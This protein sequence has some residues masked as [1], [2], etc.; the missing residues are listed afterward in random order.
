[1]TDFDKWFGASTVRDE[2]GNPK[3]VFHGTS[4]GGWSAFRKTKIGSAT[5]ADLLYGPGFYFT[6]DKSVAEEYAEIGL[7]DNPA[8]L[9]NSATINQILRAR[10]VEKKIKQGSVS[11]WAE[12]HIQHRHPSS[13]LDQIRL[14]DGIS[15]F[16]KEG[17]SIADAFPGR[18]IKEVFLSIKK[19]FNPEKDRIK[20]SQLPA[21]ILATN[22]DIKR[23]RA[24]PSLG[25]DLSYN[26]LNSAGIEKNEINKIL[27]D[28][29]Y[30]GITHTGGQ[31]MGDKEHR[32]WI[33]FEPD[34]IKYAAS[35]QELSAGQAVAPKKTLAFKHRV[36]QRFYPD[37][38]QL[39]KKLK[40]ELH[41]SPN[42]GIVTQL[43]ELGGQQRGGSSGEEPSTPVQRPQAMPSPVVSTPSVA[44]NPTSEAST[45]AKSA[46]HGTPAVSDSASNPISGNLSNLGDD[47]WSPRNFT[48]DDLKS[49][50][51]SP[52][53]NP[54]GLRNTSISGQN[55]SV[56]SLGNPPTGSTSDAHELGSVN[57]P[58]ASGSNVASVNRPGSGVSFDKVSPS[59]NVSQSQSVASIGQSA[60]AQNSNGISPKNSSSLGKSG[61]SIAN[62]PQ[63]S[64]MLD[65]LKGVASAT[66]ALTK[67]EM[68]HPG[69]EDS[70]L[71]HQS[72]R[73]AN[74]PSYGNMRGVQVGGGSEASAFHHGPES[75][76]DNLNAM[77][78]VLGNSG[79][80][81]DGF[82]GG[83]DNSNS[84]VL[85]AIKQLTEIV[86]AI[87]DKMGSSSES[88]TA[89][90]GHAGQSMAAH[91]PNWGGSHD[92][93]EISQ[94]LQAR[95]DG[96]QARHA[97]GYNPGGI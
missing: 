39:S 55:V 86:K 57:V 24:N 40:T 19:P 29:G 85:E 75:Q 14:S 36:T 23:W 3:I 38:T 94:R 22:E 9:K 21:H 43:A 52:T 70:P 88:S 74:S 95:I 50:W 72:L 97:N 41:K 61:V 68:Q 37:V 73:V 93:T 2:N 20:Y 54:S 66:L 62:T 83:G 78:G 48:D 15:K 81:T 53:P 25:T 65:L 84:E 46:L 90:G 56:G 1:M 79:G 69:F 18:E 64:K 49:Q 63:A 45:A 42:S 4:K 5:G 12:E 44:A 51:I 13:P 6:E 47:D 11:D 91:I 92:G 35:R 26:D 17:V 34:Q 59:P 71:Y 80:G 76:D 31:V 33:A 32:V 27:Q 89:G 8:V 30:D 82:A 60:G 10:L 16:K 7:Y 28:N 96:V 58:A 87:L 67:E 77:T